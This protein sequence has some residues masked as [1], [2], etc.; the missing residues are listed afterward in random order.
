MTRQAK[1]PSREVVTFA[2]WA[3]GSRARE[4][5]YAEQRDAAGTGWLAKVRARRLLAEWLEGWSAEEAVKRDAGKILRRMKI[6]R[7]RKKGR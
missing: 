5:Y 3:A 1:K 7:S 6:L 4:C 2:M